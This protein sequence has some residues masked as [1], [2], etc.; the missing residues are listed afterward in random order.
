VNGRTV[1]VTDLQPGGPGELHVT[2]EPELGDLIEAEYRDS[3]ADYDDGPGHQDH[4]EDD[5]Q[6][7]EADA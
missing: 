7:T 5:D 1:T 2:F 6:D 4:D 3:Q